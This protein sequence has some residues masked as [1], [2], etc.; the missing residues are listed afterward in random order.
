M[1]LTNAAEKGDVAAYNILAAISL[2]KD[3]YARYY[4]W[5]Y[6]YLQCKG[7]GKLPGNKGLRQYLLEVTNRDIFDMYVEFIPKP[8]TQYVT[9]GK[10]LIEAWKLGH[11]RLCIR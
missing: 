11:G 6:L 8:R 7:F 4:K 3:H 10:A 2:L 9:E 5:A 1:L